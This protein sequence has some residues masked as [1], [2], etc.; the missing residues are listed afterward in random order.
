MGG[1][2]LNLLECTLTMTALSCLLL[3][4]TPLLERR[5]SPRCLYALWL[6]VLVGFA[7]PVRPG[8]APQA[9]TVT[10]HAPE[11]E[12]LLSAPARTDPSEA[13]ACRRAAD[14]A[15]IGPFAGAGCGRDGGCD[16]WLPAGTRRV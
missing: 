8:D 6:V 15:A 3:A 16:L 13:P 14:A 1:F 12:M 11:Q 5:Y 4:L 10:L 7:V 9:M 2:L